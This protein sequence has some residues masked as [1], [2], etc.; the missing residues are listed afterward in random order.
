MSRGGCLSGGLQSK[1]GEFRLQFPDRHSPRTAC[2]PHRA[3][4]PHLRTAPHVRTFLATLD[5]DD[6][7]PFLE[8]SPRLVPETWERF[9]DHALPGIRAVDEDAVE[10]PSARY[11][12]DPVPEEAGPRVEAPALILT[13]RS[14]GSGPPR[15]RGRRETEA[16]VREARSAHPLATRPAGFPSAT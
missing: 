5:P 3:S 1:C 16:P 8:M 7:E 15:R 2:R 12:L 13:G 4:A 9:R 11:V 6:A 10:R 14:W